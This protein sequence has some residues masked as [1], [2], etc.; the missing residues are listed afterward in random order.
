[1][2]AFGIV[3]KNAIILNSSVFLGHV[4]FMYF[5]TRVHALSHLKRK[6]RAFLYLLKHKV[7]Y[8]K[9]KFKNDPSYKLTA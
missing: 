4:Y 8:F 6:F 7:L 5:L 9:I 3:K 2:S 1:M